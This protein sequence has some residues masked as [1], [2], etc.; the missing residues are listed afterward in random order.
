VSLKQ[1]EKR[2]KEKNE[3]E[4]KVIEDEKYEKRELVLICD[5]ME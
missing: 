3:E 5:V 4:R 1:R 2:V